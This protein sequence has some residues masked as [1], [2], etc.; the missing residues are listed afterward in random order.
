MN[1][2]LIAEEIGNVRKYILKEDEDFEFDEP[3]NRNKIMF[4]GVT[5]ELTDL[6]LKIYNSEDGTSIVL[7]EEEVEK[8]RDWLNTL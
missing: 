2:K 8:L 4:D 7:A 3:T 1:T 5:A 6:G